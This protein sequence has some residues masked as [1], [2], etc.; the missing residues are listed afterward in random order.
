MHAI[1]IAEENLGN[2]EEDYSTV[3]LGDVAA[4]FVSEGKDK[5]RSADILVKMNAMTDRPWNT[6]GRQRQPITNRILSSLLR[7]FGIKPK[8]LRFSNVQSDTG[9][10][11][12][13]APV[14]EARDRF[15]EEEAVELEEEAF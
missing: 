6:W 3:A 1:K 15:V 7:P 11:Y 9:S 8:Q 2:H 14:L 10:G 12:A 4:I 5:L 13:R